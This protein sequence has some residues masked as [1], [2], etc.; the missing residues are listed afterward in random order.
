MFYHCIIVE[1]FFLLCQLRL[2]LKYHNYQRKQKAPPYAGYNN[3]HSS[4]M[5]SRHHLAISNG[6][7]SYEHNPQAVV[8]SIEFCIWHRA[9]KNKQK[10]S[11]DNNGY[12]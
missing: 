10:E 5:R 6:R 9:F 2:L 8:Q 12:A 3:H 7:Y 1:Q 4:E 11:A